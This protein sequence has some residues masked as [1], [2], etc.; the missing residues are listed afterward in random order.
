M[1]TMFRAAII[2]LFLSSVLLQLV[3][4]K[5][6]DGFVRIRLKKFKLDENNR[7]SARLT[8]QLL[9]SQNAGGIVKLKNYMNAQYYGEISIGTPPQKFTVV[10]DT[11]SSNLWIPSS[12][13]YFSWAC[14]YHSKYNAGRSRT[15]KVKGT[16]AEIHYGSGSI[17]GKFS[18]DNVLVGGLTIKNQD[19][20]EVTKLSGNVFVFTKF[21]GILGL[22]F[23]EISAGSVAPLWYNMMNQGLVQ[24]PVFSFW[25]NRNTKEEEGG[26]LVFGEIDPR[27]YKGNHTYVPVTHKGFWQFDMGDIF[28]KGQPIGVCR[29][30][31]SAI[32]DSGTSLLTGP[33][34]VITMINHE[35]GITKVVNDRCNSFVEVYGQIILKK[36][37]K[38]QPEEICSLIGVCPVDETKCIEKSNKCNKEIINRRIDICNT[39][40][41]IVVWMESLLWRNQ[42]EDVILNYVNKLC[43]SLPRPDQDKHSYVNCSLI[44]SMPIVSFVIGE[45]NFTISPKEYIMK[46][47]EGG[48]HDCISGFVSRESLWVFGDIFMGRYHTVF[49]YG[50]SRIGF[51]DA[52]LY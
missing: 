37:L 5:S 7:I 4:S 50:E 42:T 6:N 27:H 25:L 8:T 20:L 34:A 38:V 39:C 23:K 14:Y 43:N 40:E 36:L 21:D 45:R 12:K 19:F 3:F 15:Y 22:G 30:G 26:E 24:N 49:D 48:G 52:A 35:I 1:G 13:C 2:I 33:P 17:V 31:C 16:Y 29:F 32:V 51:A 11:G 46:T 47:G 18:Q 9:D 44:S 41:I 10:F 28:L